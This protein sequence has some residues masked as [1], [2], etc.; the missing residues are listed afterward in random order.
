VFVGVLLQNHLDAYPQPKSLADSVQR[1]FSDPI[2]LAILLGIALLFSLSCFRD[3]AQVRSKPWSEFY[4]DRLETAL[5]AGR[6]IETASQHEEPEL[7][8]GVSARELFGLNS[9]FTKAELQRAWLRL[10]RELHP[11]RWMH[12]GDGVRRMKEAA[13]KRVNA[14]RDELMAEVT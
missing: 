12:A 6:G 3:A 10:A 2:L 11:D 8:D 1:V 4:G 9:G 7:P 14:A 13:L 5:K